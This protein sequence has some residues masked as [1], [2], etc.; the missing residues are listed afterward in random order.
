MQAR[1]IIKVL[2]WVMFCFFIGTISLYAE[3]QTALCPKGDYNE[4]CK[5][6]LKEAIYAL[7]VSSGMHSFDNVEECEKI[8][9][10]STSAIADIQQT[11]DSLKKMVK[12]LSKIDLSELSLKL[13]SAPLDPKSFDFNFSCGSVSL[14]GKSALFTFNDS[15][16]GISGKITINFD[17]NT[18]IFDNLIVDDCLINGSASGR[19]SFH[20]HSISALLTFNEFSLCGYY[21]HGTY[22]ISYESETGLVIAIQ[23][24]FSNEYAVDE[25]KITLSLDAIYSQA[26]GLSGTAILFIDDKKYD[27]AFSKI[28]IDSS[29]RVP[30]SGYLKYNEYAISFVDTTCENPKVRIT[31]NGFTFSISLNSIIL[32][33]MTPA[34]ISEEIKK[35]DDTLPLNEMPDFNT[36][37]GLSFSPFVKDI[38]QTYATEL[39]PCGTI[40]IDKMFPFSARINLSGDS[41]CLGISGQM[42][43]KSTIFDGKATIIFTDVMYETYQITGTVYASIT[44]QDCGYIAELTTHD[45][46]LGDIHL[47]GTA[48]AKSHSKTNGEILFGLNGNGSIT[49]DN[50]LIQGEANVSYV[51]NNGANGTA[52][53]KFDQQSYVV[54]MKKVMINHDTFVPTSGVIVLNGMSFSV[55]D[56]INHLFHP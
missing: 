38:V 19:V 21:I 29:C 8:V 40:T 33:K 45:F 46:S 27:L 18:F 2:I 17:N 16:S 41:K 51:P 34:S 6:D 9:N 26:T 3:E 32:K 48:Y 54:E 23:Q 35:I 4:D 50:V 13:R 42:E 14:E 49:W 43:V 36:P 47:D 39:F 56:I 55:T 7:Q 15:C 1:S 53:L 30:T 31:I 22:D 24:D 25:D 37:N 44:V 28:S 10:V 12:A 20:S 11:Y 5:V 52:Q